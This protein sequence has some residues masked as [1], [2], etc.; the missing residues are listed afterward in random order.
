MSAQKIAFLFPGQ[1]A[2]KVGMG[3]DLYRQFDVAK[4]LLNQ[5][6]DAFTPP[7]GHPS[8]LEVMFQGPSEVL[9]RTLYTQ[10][11]I[12]AVSLVCLALFK[13]QLPDLQ[14]VAVAGHS[15]GEFSALYSAGVLNVESV[16]RMVQQRASLMETAPAG[17]MA[18]VLGLDARTVQ[19]TLDSF[20]FQGEDWASIAND[21]SATQVVLSGSPAG[22]EA[23]SPVLK[24]A[25]AKRIVPLSVGGAFHSVLMNAP[26]KAFEPAIKEAQY[27]TAQVPVVMNVNALATQEAD[28]L[29]S[30]S[31]LQMTS[32]V[33][34]NATMNE[35]VHT[36]GV[37]AVIE[38]G[39][40]TVLTGL[41]KKA[42]PAVEVYNVS[43]GPSLQATV[44]SLQG[45]GAPVVS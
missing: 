38:F 8:L 26:A 23:V 31:S 21:N 16:V 24:E 13:E 33:Q 39:P 10:P 1:G 28:A 40:G 6:S 22:L 12:L 42:F 36:H 3:E 4:T 41:M 9:N 43:D 25:G 30:L 14:P 44:T 11:A 2:Q 32:S 27:Q 15:L 45:V 5:V 19:H 29:I 37:N 18:A 17:T 35:L 20:T 7:T 34:W